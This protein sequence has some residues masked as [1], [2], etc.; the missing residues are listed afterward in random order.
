[1]TK[2]KYAFI[3]NSATQTPET[4]K[5]IH[6]NRNSYFLIA[7]VNSMEMAAEL[8]RELSEKEFTVIDLCGD[9][10][11]E[12]AAVIAEAAGGKIEV[13]YAKYSSE[14]LEKLDALE[15]MTEYGVILMESSLPEIEWSRL[16]CD[17]FK[18]TVAFVNSLESACTAAAEMIE[19][20]VN[21][22]EMCG[23]FDEE[24]TKEVI[25]SIGGAVP[26]GY[27]G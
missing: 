23:W 8:A 14:D 10:D 18:T 2:F 16:E 9:F 13:G 27:C 22:I 6:E 25:K 11:E 3:M 20:G 12:K 5:E 15:S 7:A 26:V 4:Y 21:F 1:M 17:E 19:D 24:K